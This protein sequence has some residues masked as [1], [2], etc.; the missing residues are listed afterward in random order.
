M[1]IEKKIEQIFKK[2]KIIKRNILQIS[3][4]IVCEKIILD[5]NHKFIAKYYN[6]NK[7]MFNSVAVEAKSLKFLS[8]LNLTI[9]P[10]VFYFDN[11]ILI[12]EFI[13]NDKIKPSGFDNNFLETILNI[14]SF[15][16]NKFGFKFDTQIGGMKQPNE[17]DSNWANFFSNQR[18]LIMY[19]AISRTSP[20]PNKIN[21]KIEKLIKK[22]SEF[23]PDN[24]KPSLV[25]GD[26]WEGNMLF[27]NKKL[28]GL[29]DPGIFYGHNEM[30]LAYLRW[31]KIVDKKFIQKYDNYSKLNKNYYE[32]EPIYQLYYS[33]SNIHLWSRNYIN[34]TAK[35]LKKI[36]I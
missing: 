15:S 9:F 3:F 5:N 31:F 27:K 20:M 7:G 30:E 19:E 12:I 11:E 24:P 36:K 26:L 10:N 28:V 8:G 32:Y 25:H 16:N 23:I 4:D 34:D 18:L 35:L 2:H 17:Y 14:H 33:L 6:N 22:I 1:F 21:I 13:E 29:I